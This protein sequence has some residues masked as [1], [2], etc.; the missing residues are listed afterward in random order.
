MPPHLSVADVRLALHALRYAWYEDMSPDQPFLF[1]A[2][3]IDRRAEGGGHLSIAEFGCVFDYAQHI[4]R[5]QRMLPRR[6][7]AERQGGEDLR[8]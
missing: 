3:A 5:H 4:K 7:A 6:K 1:S 2:T 8:P